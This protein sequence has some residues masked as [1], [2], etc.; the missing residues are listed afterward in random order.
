MFVFVF[1]TSRQLKLHGCPPN[2]QKINICLS[3]LTYPGESGQISSAL[4]F[5]GSIFLLGSWKNLSLQSELFT[6]N[7]KIDSP[8]LFFF[9][10][11]PGTKLKV[12]VAQSD[13]LQRI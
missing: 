12:L 13:S 11:Y 1:L 3:D 7:H 10:A 5:K 4:P 8:L 2:E 9:L 6:Q